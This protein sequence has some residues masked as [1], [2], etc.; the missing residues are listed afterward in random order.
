MKMEPYY[1]VV[2]F[3][4]F[5]KM[6]AIGDTYM[7]ILYFWNI[8]G[9]VQDFRLDRKLGTSLLHDKLHF[10]GFVRDVTLFTQ[11]VFESQEVSAK[12]SVYGSVFFRCM[13]TLLN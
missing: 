11:V 5:H 8:S 6:L 13:N 3:L 12:R 7:Y 4:K 1:L 9:H 2:I 10:F